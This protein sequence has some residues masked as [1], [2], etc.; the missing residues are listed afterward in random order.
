MRQIAEK[1]RNCDKRGGTLVVMVHRQPPTLLHA[2]RFV[3][4][5]LLEGMRRNFHGGV[6][7]ED[8]AIHVDEPVYRSFAKSKEHSLGYRTGEPINL[9]KSIF[10]EVGPTCG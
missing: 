10:V 4:K 7:V 1:P 6:K 9:R 8:E 3:R 2:H 5:N